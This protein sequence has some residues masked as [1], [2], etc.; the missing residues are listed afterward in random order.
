MISFQC[1][2]FS[3]YAG[4]CKNA[5]EHDTILFMTV[6]PEVEMETQSHLTCCHCGGGGSTHFSH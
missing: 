4:E 2:F 1:H 3:Y 6:L 5:D